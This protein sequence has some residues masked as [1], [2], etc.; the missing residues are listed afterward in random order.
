MS[1][2]SEKKAKCVGKPFEEPLRV[3]SIVSVD[4]RGQMVLPKEVRDRAGIKP[5]DK[6][7]LVTRERNRQVC[8]IYLFKSEVLTP[9]VKGLVGPL[10]REP[11]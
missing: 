1:K 2:P 10:T 11:K 3:E 6:L 9:R 5:G 8:C 7:A 4:E